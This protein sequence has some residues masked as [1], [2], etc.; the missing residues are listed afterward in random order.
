MDFESAGRMNKITELRA[1]R[2]LLVQRQEAVQAQIR[3]AKESGKP[4]VPEGLEQAQTELTQA[5]ETIDRI[6]QELTELT[7]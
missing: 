7:S 3:E 2:D 4:L 1:H 6:D 5:Q